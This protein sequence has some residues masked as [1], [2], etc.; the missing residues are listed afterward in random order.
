MCHAPEVADLHVQLGHALIDVL[1]RGR[2]SVQHERR[3]LGV[4]R[5]IATDDKI[6]LSLRTL[7]LN[8]NVTIFLVVLDERFEVLC[9]IQNL[10]RG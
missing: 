4:G 1:S 10:Q 9:T 3:R 5:E 6:R 8:L 7:E 2:P